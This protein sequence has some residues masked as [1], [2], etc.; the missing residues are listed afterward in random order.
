MTLADLLT[1][2]D[3]RAALPPS[4]LKDC[5]TSLRYLAH[6]LGYKTLEECP[7]DEA[8]E[9]T[10]KWKDKLEEHF[11]ALTDQGRT[12]GAMTRRNTRNNCRTIFRQAEAHGLLHTALPSRLLAKP[13]RNAF[14]QQYH[15]TAPYQT[16]YHPQNSPRRYG[17]PQ[18][19]WPPDIVQGWQRYQAKCGLRLREESFGTYAKCLTSYLGYL[20]HICGRQPVWEDLFDTA[21]L[22]AFV[23]WH[24]VRVGRPVSTHARL[25]VVVLATIAQVLRHDHAPALAE[26][27]KGLKHP[28]PMHAK[29]LHWVSLAQ[30]EA[31]ADAYLSAGRIPVAVRPTTRSP[32]TIGR[33]AFNS[34]SY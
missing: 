16:T 6:A 24:G 30:L 14:K 1:E 29:H 4:R 5:K 22:T 12:I 28:A 3:T 9:K 27:R 18:T 8:C 26:M 21:Q 33:P 11:Q 15:A 31:V 7:V 13:R 23:R 34:A 20:V 25:V 19:Q 2:L 32:G 17:L 10:E